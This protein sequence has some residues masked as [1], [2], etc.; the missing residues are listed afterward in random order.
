MT[1][2]CLCDN[3][4]SLT[5]LHRNFSLGKKLS[6]WNKIDL[7]VQTWSS[8]VSGMFEQDNAYLLV[9]YTVPKKHDFYQKK[10]YF[11]RR[12]LTGNVFTQYYAIH[13]RW[14]LFA[15]RE[16]QQSKLMNNKSL[17]GHITMQGRAVFL[18]YFLFCPLNMA[19]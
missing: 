6:D 10:N 12:K 1:Y 5:P 9:S 11:L 16:S 19:I 8:L 14:S 13:I 15:S 7:I 17:S 18:L 2:Y 4:N 3:R